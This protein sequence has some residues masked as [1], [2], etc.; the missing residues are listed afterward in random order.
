M[1]G[2]AKRLIA[3]YIFRLFCTD[4]DTK[5]HIITSSVLFVNPQIK[6]YKKCMLHRIFKWY[7][8]LKNK[9]EFCPWGGAI[10]T[11]YEITGMQIRIS[12]MMQ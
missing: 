7:N 10:A 11:D 1:S 3:I 6:V 9:Y 12:L 4:A 5:R 2:L 8:K